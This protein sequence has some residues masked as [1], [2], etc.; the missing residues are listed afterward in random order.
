MYEV[1]VNE[2]FIDSPTVHLR[3]ET[4]PTQVPFVFI[5]LSS[6]CIDTEKNILL[7]ILYVLYDVDIKHTYAVSSVDS[8]PCTP[9]NSKLDCSPADIQIHHMVDL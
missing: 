5:N 4:D 9:D 1:S 6:D 3:G 2:V 8:L 7:G